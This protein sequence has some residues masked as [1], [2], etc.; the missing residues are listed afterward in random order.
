MISAPTA[1]Q[2]GLELVGVVQH[3]EERSVF[4]ATPKM[5]KIAAGTM[6]IVIW[7]VV[8]EEADAEEKR[9]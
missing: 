1:E 7:Q 8:V 6:A 5:D 2:W 4:A 9:V 3:A